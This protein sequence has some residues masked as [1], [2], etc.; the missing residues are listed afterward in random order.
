MHSS[1]STNNAP[2]GVQVITSARLGT[3]W[4]P[5]HL[6]CG[7]SFRLHSR[8]DFSG[9]HGGGEG[10]FVFYGRVLTPDL[11]RSQDGRSIPRHV[12]PR[13][14]RSRCK[15]W[16]SLIGGILLSPSI[17]LH[18]HILLDHS[19]IGQYRSL[20]S[21]PSAEIMPFSLVPPFEDI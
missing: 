10:T 4:H 3:S 7:C 20:S 1:C 15:F 9:S 16:N 5:P 8:P 19:C 13:A 17:I 18:P 11:G 6:F 21:L 12:L 14:F 2:G